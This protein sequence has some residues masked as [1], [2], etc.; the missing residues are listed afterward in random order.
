MTDVPDTVTDALADV[1]VD[2]A[3]ALEAG[4]GVGN[5]TAGLRNAGAA[6]VYAVTADRA[7][8]ASVRERIPAA[9]VLQADLRSIPLPDDT[10]DVVFAHALFNV[11]TNAEATAIADELTRV[12]APD[13]WLVV[14]DYAP[15]GRDE[16]IRRLFGVENAL[17]ELADGR[18]AYVFHPDTELRALFEARGWTHERTRDILEPVPWPRDLFDAHLDAARDTAASVPDHLADPLL[19]RARELTERAP[20]STGR[21]YSVAMRR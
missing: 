1:P 4:A 8:A 6:A 3:V 10:V 12:A 2:G 5:G 7:H 17:A 14:D 15:V 21:M 11:L 20:N 19:D 16:P 9:A 13:A 18:P